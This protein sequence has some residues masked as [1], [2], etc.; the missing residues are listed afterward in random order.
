MFSNIFYSDCSI[1]TDRIVIEDKEQHGQTSI[2][3]NDL[4]IDVNKSTEVV[5][6][7]IN[8]NAT[9]KEQ[10]RRTFK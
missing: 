2:H 7:I 3:F 1:Q 5:S 9:E 4:V 8:T 6:P 10:I